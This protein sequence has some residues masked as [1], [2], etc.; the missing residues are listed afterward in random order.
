VARTARQLISRRR[1]GG[2]P[3]AARRRP[4]AAA[5]ARRRHWL[6]HRS[7]GEQGSAGSAGDRGVG[8]NPPRHTLHKVAF[9]P[10][11]TRARRAHGPTPPTPPRDGATTCPRGAAGR[12][13]GR[14][15]GSVSAPAWTP[16]MDW[17][18]LAWSAM[19]CHGGTEAAAWRR[20]YAVTG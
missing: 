20:D 2:G 14:L 3:A 16:T 7:R 1:P 5:A 15:G 8:G 18:S 13:G 12:E 4:S 10:C 9:T 19:D 17:L 6:V 11:H